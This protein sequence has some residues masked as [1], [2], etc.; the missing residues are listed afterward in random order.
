MSILLKAPIRKTG[1]ITKSK[2]VGPKT[3]SILLVSA[4]IF[5]AVVLFMY[6]GIAFTEGTMKGYSE[7]RDKIVGFEQKGIYGSPDQFK[8]ALSYCNPK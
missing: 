5:I 8:L 1:L 2:H 7:C 4:T 3:S 6:T